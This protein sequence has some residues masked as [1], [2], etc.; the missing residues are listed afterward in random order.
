ML[1]LVS[2]SCYD[3]GNIITTK[4]HRAFKMVTTYCF[5]SKD[6]PYLRLIIDILLM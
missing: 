5:Y 2:D 3:E 1:G 4:E 6:I